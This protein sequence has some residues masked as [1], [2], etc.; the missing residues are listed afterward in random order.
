VL[1]SLA[2]AAAAGLAVWAAPSL[3][4]LFSR[5]EVVRDWVR[6]WGPW[7]PAAFVLLQVLQV[8][9]FVLPGEI[10]QIAGG[11]L[12]GFGWGSV[13]S[14]T[15]ILVG[16]SVAFGL[17]R[18]LGVTFV[19]RIAGPG[20]VARFDTLMASP[21]LV[22]SVFLLFLIPGIPKDVLCYV[23]GLSRLRFLPFLVISS[24]ARLPGILGSSLMGKAL[25]DQNWHLLAGVAGA[26]LVLF[27]LGWWFRESIFAFIERFALT[28][29]IPKEIPHEPR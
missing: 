2:V 19:H 3:W 28:Q 5:P 8:V 24:L 21:K 14:V 10:T 26:A 20:A 11:W 25:V 22:G 23:A 13:L 6:S 1:P 17:T 16:S 29:P 15:G 18:W 12:F 9:V 4:T 27:G 7:A